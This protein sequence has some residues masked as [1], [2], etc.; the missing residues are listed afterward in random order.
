MLRRPSRP[1]RDAFTLIELLVVVLIIA[2]LVSLLLPAIQKVRQFS[3]RA[4][5][6]N[7]VNQITNAAA[8]F[9]TDWGDQPPPNTFCLP[10]R[11]PASIAGP[12][13]TGANAAQMDASFAFLQAKYSGG[14]NRW[15]KAGVDF[16]AATGVITWDASWSAIFAYNTNSDANPLLQG[17]QCM[18]LF[19]AGPIQTGWAMDRPAAPSA[20]ATSQMKYLEVTQNNLNTATGVS[21]MLTFGYPSNAPVYMDPYG[22]PYVYFGSNKVGK[23]YTGVPAFGGVSPYNEAANGKW[24][25]EGGCQVISAGENKAFGPGGAWVP[26]A[27]AG[28][29]PEQPGADDMANF[30]GGLLLGVV[31]R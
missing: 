5:V 22:M 30:N 28:Y 19:L 27:S 8:N 9:K 6:S 14:S 17:N 20:T 25:N 26:G 7:E 3:K 12:G 18:L 10:F 1:A 16:N 2:I 15:P 4:Q 29:A 23:K 21:P 24:L 31:G 13:N 11:V